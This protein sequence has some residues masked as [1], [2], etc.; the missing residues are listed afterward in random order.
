MSIDILKNNVS[1]MK[2]IVKEMY[3]F[4]N[5]LD[6][7]KNIESNSS[8]ILNT[9]EKKLLKDV[10]EGLENQLKILNNSIPE[11][12]ENIG[13]F[14][15]LKENSKIEEA[16]KNKLIQVKF[17]PEESNEKISY[18]ISDADKK[19]FLNNLSKT[20]L[21]IMQLK[22]NYSFEKPLPSFGKPNYYAKLSNKFFRELSNKLL[23]E[24]YFYNLNLNL[25]KM[26]SPFVAG[27]Y[28]SMIFFTTALSFIFSIFLLITLLFYDISL[29]F[30][31]LFSINEHPLL[32][33]A[34]FFWV[35]F[36]VPL[37][38]G[39]LM[40]IYPSSE[41][42]NLGSK[43]DQEL[44]FIAIHMS[45]ITTSGIEPLSIF[46]II[47]KSSEY[48]YTNMEIRK[49]M[50]LINFHGK[51]LVTA[52]KITS[53]TCPSNKLKELFDGLATT[54]T[55]GGDLH[56]FLEKHADSLL[57]DY[58]LER[59]KYTKTSET[60]M[61]IYI[62][63]VIA[64]PMILLMLFVIMGSTGILANFLGF[65]TEIISFLIILIIILLNIGFLI[66]LKIKQPNF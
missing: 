13:F 24:G 39:I 43:I 20:N 48:K 64:A 59:E 31:F 25:R 34:K 18:V 17:T 16:K 8:I 6:G 40:Y 38:T 21:S 7:I 62:S 9:K 44:P 46:K 10:V 30:P 3:I 35:I 26:N 23:S 32:R 11:L 19:E 47:L 28:V 60:F 49:L 14:K 51:D 33:F 58:R 27:T 56:E 63:I 41:A 36:A 2:N 1:H 15:K 45:A 50:N 66:F 53:K 65:S 55:S 22:K 42:K 52:L 5:Q 61:D 37:I 57:F 54:M 12:V 29:S 4:L